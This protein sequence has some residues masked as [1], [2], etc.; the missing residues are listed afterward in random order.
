MKMA[1]ILLLL[2]VGLSGECFA[3]VSDPNVLALGDWSESVDNGNGFKLRGRLLIC[4]F[5]EHRGGAG[6]DAA[7]Y[8][9]LQEY[10]DS[11]GAVGEVHWS[12]EALTCELTDRSG[13]TVPPSSEA[14]GGPVPEGCWIKLPS[15]SSMRLRVSPY[16]GGK[17]SDGGF[18]IWASVMDVWTLKPGDT[19]TYF[20]SGKFTVKPAAD[21][22]PVNFNWVWT[23]TLKLPKME[24]SLRKLR[25]VK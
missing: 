22:K 17:L 3:G 10:S 13:K 12:P 11:V 19:K 15:H 9:E 1:S 16:A 5:P 24:V 8:V 2:V 18:G 6:T 21:Y 7:L 25:D 14:Y 4:E 23:G 20:L